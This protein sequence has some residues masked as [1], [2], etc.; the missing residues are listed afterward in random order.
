[1]IARNLLV[2]VEG[3][4]QRLDAGQPL[5]A[6]HAI[7]AGHDQAQGKAVLGQQRCPVHGPDE[8]HVVAQGHLAP[9]A[10]AKGVLM[11]AVEAA[12]GADEGDVDGVVT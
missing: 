2:A 7:P 11:P 3:L 5:H 4:R 1:M 10:A 6:R 8:Q 9:Q 12:V